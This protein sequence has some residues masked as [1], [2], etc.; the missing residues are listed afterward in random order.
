MDRTIVSGMATASSSLAGVFLGGFVHSAH[1]KPL[2][3]VLGVVFAAG[4]VAAWI[5]LVRTAPKP[6][7][8]PKAPGDMSI[9]EALVYIAGDSTWSETGGR[10]RRWFDQLE[11]DV[12]DSLVGGF[13][14]A[15]GR[16]ER[17]TRKPH[18]WPA[19]VKIN[20][21]RWI[22]GRIPVEYFVLAK[23]NG[24]FGLLGYHEVTVHREQVEDIWPRAKPGHVNPLEMANFIGGRGRPFPRVEPSPSGYQRLA[25]FI[26]R[27]WPP[28][29]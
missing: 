4:A 29:S 27:F 15:Y 5:Y 26:G 6:A 10:S 13:L 11:R 19:A 24:P 8:A 3:I 17:T 23:P 20:P 14:Q 28:R 16:E 25:G 9:P 21:E 12:L 22:D 2:S 1:P 18:V 7:F